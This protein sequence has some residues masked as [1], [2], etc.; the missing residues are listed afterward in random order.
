MLQH[1]LAL[2]RIARQQRLQHPGDLFAPDQTA[3]RAAIPGLCGDGVCVGITFRQIPVDLRDE[4]LEPA[5]SH[6]LGLASEECRELQKCLRLLRQV[7]LFT[8]ASQIGAQHAHLHGRH[9]PLHVRFL[10]QGR[11]I[12]RGTL[13]AEGLLARSTPGTLPVLGKVFP[14]RSRRDACLRDA[15]ALVVSIGTHRTN[16]FSHGPHRLLWNHYSIFRAIFRDKITKKF[17][18]FMPKARSRRLCRDPGCA[19]RAFVV[20]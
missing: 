14:F 12:L 10:R 11:G 9:L 2:A 13:F 6:W 4:R 3:L 8:A 16:E 19:T 20:Q 17:L 15:L 18:F 5:R 1:P 7:L